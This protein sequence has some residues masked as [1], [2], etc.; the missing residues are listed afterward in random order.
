MKRD[1]WIF[2]IITLSLVS[3]T[4]MALARERSWI[5]WGQSPLHVKLVASSAK[6]LKPGMEVRLSGMAVG[7]LADISLSPDARIQGL[8]KIEREYAK[9]VG[10]SSHLSV[11]QD[12]ILG[13][14]FLSLTPDSSSLKFKP[15]SSDAPQLALEP[16]VDARDLLIAIAKTRMNLDSTISKAGGL[17][18]KDLPATLTVVLRGVSSFVSL[19]DS[20]EEE[21]RTTAPGLRSVLGDA[22]GTLH[23]VG[24]AGSSARLTSDEIRHL[25]QLLRKLLN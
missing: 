3:V 16:P 21:V 6:F 14:Y 23:Q 9:Y 11:D 15:K 22:R 5:P 24:E 12:G 13:E 2:S 7:R 8:M 17:A 18:A 20:L 19:A 10:P 25:V 4:L 1:S